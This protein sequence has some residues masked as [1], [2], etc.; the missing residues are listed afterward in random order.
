MDEDKAFEQKIKGQMTNGT[1]PCQM[2]NMEPQKSVLKTVTCT[3]CGK[4]FKTNSND[5]MCFSCH[6]KA[7]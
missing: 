3:V 7:R 4:T 6:K 5:R 1:C 2:T